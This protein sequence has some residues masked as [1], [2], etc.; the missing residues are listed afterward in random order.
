MAVVYLEDLTVGLERSRT[1]KVTMEAIRAFA[2][3]T[4][5]RNPVH[6]D[7]EYAKTTPF[8]GVIAHGI[9]SAGFISALIASELPG[10]GTVYLKQGLSFRA[11][12][13]PGDAVT[14]TCRVAA[15]DAAKA[16][17]TLECE[18]RVGETV[19]VQGEAMVLA[20]KRPA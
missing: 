15:I 19:V 14:T 11:P 18:C 3:V 8:G 5:D 13:R 16:R 6:L 7:E 1:D 2:D 10:E 12:V 9:L 4:G 17:V 20:P